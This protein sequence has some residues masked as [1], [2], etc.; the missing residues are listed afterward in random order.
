MVGIG[1]V[2]LLRPG[3]NRKQKKT[4][5][6]EILVLVLRVRPSRAA[7]AGPTRVEAET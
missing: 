3:G 5:L 4:P 2:P 1:E 6:S 7:H